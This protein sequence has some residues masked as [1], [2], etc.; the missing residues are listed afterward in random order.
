M[1]DSFKI[2]NESHKNGLVG[3][4]STEKIDIFYIVSE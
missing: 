3:C 1:I 2:V 4:L